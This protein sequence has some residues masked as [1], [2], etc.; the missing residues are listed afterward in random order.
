MAVVA[1][2]AMAVMAAPARAAMEEAVLVV[3]AVPTPEV[4]AVMA[5]PAVA[6]VPAVPP[7]AVT[8][9]FCQAGLGALAVPVVRGVRLPAQTQVPSMFQ[10]RHRE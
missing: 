4:P 5:V 9:G 8:A 7:T 3:M 10:T 6:A 1:A 2:P